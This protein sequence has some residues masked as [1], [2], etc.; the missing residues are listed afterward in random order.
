MPKKFYQISPASSLSDSSTS[1]NSSASYGK[2]LNLHLPHSAAGAATVSQ[3]A[4]LSRSSSSSNNGGQDS[5]CGPVMALPEGWDVATDN[6]GKIYYIDHN[7]KSTTW[8]DPR[9]RWV[10]TH[11]RWHEAKMSNCS[12]CAVVDCSLII[13]YRLRYC[14]YRL[15]VIAHSWALRESQS[16]KL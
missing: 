12:E 6:D 8:I 5:W 1:I 15:G 16:A 2:G 9:D 7:T 4:L 13:S 11:S 10:Y 3:V 14:K